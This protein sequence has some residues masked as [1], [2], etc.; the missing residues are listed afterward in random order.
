MDIF[1][2]DTE[3]T[4]QLAETE[5]EY[6]KT[7]DFNF[8]ESLNNDC[9]G[10]VMEATVIYLEIKNIDF[11]LRT[12]KR[13]AART[14]KIYYHVLQEVC[15][16]TGGHFSCYSPNSFLLI[17]PKSM[18][19]ESFV[20]DTAIKTA[21]LLNITLRETIEKLTH[22][23]FGI[24]VDHG[25]VLGTKA[26]DGNGYP[27]IAWFGNP[28]EKAITIARLSQRPF[29]VSITRSVHHLL[30]DDLLTSTKNILGFKKE[31]DLW[32]RQSYQFDNVKKY[33]Y[34]TNAIRTF[35]DE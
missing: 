26:F 5:F 18:Y 28:I 3:K 15:Q 10:I 7:S 32:T 8:M 9:T 6:S 13:L 23:N 11:M 30:N 17:Y 29:F 4:N 24:G 25:N 14:Y 16:A 31:V 27:H 20:V 1:Q 33:L 34:Q 2:K 19:D 12:G 22:L 35:N 21:N